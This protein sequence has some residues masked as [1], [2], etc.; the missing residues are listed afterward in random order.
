MAYEIPVI[1][2]GNFDNDPKQVA[3]KVLEACKSI[4]FFYMVNHGI[5]KDQIDRSFELAKEFFDTPANEKRKYLIQED[6]HGY[7]ELYQETLDPENQKQGDHKEGF[8]FRNFVNGKAHAPLPAVFEKEH[9]FVEGFS[10]ACHGMAMR[11]LQAFAIA[12]EIPEEEGGANWF[13][14]R[15]TYDEQSGQILRYLKYPRG[16]ESTYQEPVRAGAHSDYGSITLLFQKDVPGLEVKAS[17]TEW[18]SAPLIENS[19]LVNV[20]DQMQE[21]T[22]GLFKSTLH[23]VTFLPE[24]AHLDR[25]S[26]PFFV[27]PED[28]TLLSPIPSKVVPP[29]SESTQGVA[30]SGEIITAG[31]HLRRRLDA[32]YK[33]EDEATN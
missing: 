1:D 17:R 7:S 25:Y 26:M 4:G 31:E 5:A 10:R 29:P 22:N 30:K 14:D 23:R 9:A 13:A 33:Y 20:G 27:H 6:N 8:N 11:V 32:T 21:W 3:Q 28:A 15:H 19:I 16:G 2:F 12:L 18:I 24:H